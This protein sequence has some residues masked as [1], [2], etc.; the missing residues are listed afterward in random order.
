MQAPPCDTFVSHIEWIMQ[1]SSATAGRCCHNSLIGIPESPPDHRIE[2]VYQQ[3]FS[4]QPTAQESARAAAFL[5]DY[6]VTVSAEQSE[7]NSLS[8]FCHSL[9]LTSE[10]VHVE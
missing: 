9:I 3:L 2:E 1:S 7:H 5:N 6:G 4:R 8:A 10:F